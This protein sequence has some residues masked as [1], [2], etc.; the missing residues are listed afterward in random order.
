MIQYDK[1]HQLLTLET[2]RTS[3]QMKI[4]KGGFLSHLYYGRRI[5]HEDMSYLIRNYDRGF[6]GNPYMIR[7]DRTFSL[8]TLPQEYTSSGVGDFRIGSIA[9]RNYDGSFGADFRYEGHEIRSGKY[10]IPGLPSV[11]DNGQDAETLIVTLKDSVTS[12]TVKLYYGVFPEQDVIT[13]AAEIVNTGTGAVTLNRAASACLDLSA[14]S[15]D[16][17]HFHGRH[18]MERQYER[19]PLTHSIQTV[20][21]KRG[22]SSHQ[23]SPFVILCDHEGCGRDP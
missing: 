8:D 12:V 10:E 23:H 21:S 9:V 14:G 22:I 13:R 2:R 6:S 19:S 4:M 3:Y 7:D 11:Y 5:P 17:I 16:L 15:W 20:A 1:H 18:C